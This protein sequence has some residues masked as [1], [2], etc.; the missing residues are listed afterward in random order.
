[1]PKF[2]DLEKYVND[3]WKTAAALADHLQVSKQLVS[4]WLNKK[5]RVSEKYRKILQGLEPPYDGPFTELSSD[6]TQ[7]D[8]QALGR[9][10]G[11]MIDYAHEDLKRD[12]QAQGAA[13]A[14]I[15]AELQAMRENR[16][17]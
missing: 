15:L 1:M 5:A 3:V 2:E 17:G 12:I 7:E 16:K 13:M 9:D 4:Q 10:L 11:R 14:A 6:I 8:F